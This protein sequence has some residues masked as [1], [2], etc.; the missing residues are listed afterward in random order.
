MDVTPVH[1]V[2]VAFFGSSLF[3]GVSSFSAPAQ[4]QTS[5]SAALAVLPR[6]PFTIQRGARQLLQKGQHVHMYFFAATPADRNT[7]CH[8]FL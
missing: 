1:R 3:L 6:M 8:Y 4:P 7:T 2:I 5:S